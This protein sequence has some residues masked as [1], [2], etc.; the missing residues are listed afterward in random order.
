MNTNDKLRVGL[1]GAGGNTR[2]R[3]LPGF[4]SAGGVEVAAVA[5]RTRSSGE[6][7]AAEWNIPVVCDDWREILADDSIDAVCIG[8]WP[9]LHR[10]ATVAALAAGK[11][12]LCEARMARDLAEAREMCRAA[13]EHPGLVAQLVPSPFTLGVDAWIAERLRSGAIGEPL[14]TR[15]R[16]LNG[17]LCD[18]RAPMNWRFDHGISGKNTMVLGIYH[19]AVLRWLDFPEARVSAAAGWGASARPVAG[20]GERPTVIPESVQVALRSGEGRRLLYDISQLQAGEPENTITI[21]GREGRLLVD[22][23]EGSAALVSNSGLRESVPVGDAWDV[24]ARFVRSI[25]E[26]A[27]VERT[28][29]TTGLEYMRFTEAVWE[30]WNTGRE[31]PLAAM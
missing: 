19:E 15:V 14:E 28:D 18:P 25:R 6:E 9:N 26:G 16:V 11:H 20:G 5:N 10:E 4:R 1:I 23:R 3:H 29:F 8:T 12:V 24:E 21:G 22:L 17:Y 7:V 31:V 30:S 2:L 27:P 13:A